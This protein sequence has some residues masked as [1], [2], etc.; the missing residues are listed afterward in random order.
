MQGEVEASAAGRG[1]GD[2][3]DQQTHPAQHQGVSSA[4][5]P[6]PTPAHLRDHGPM[7][8][9]PSL[10]HWSRAQYVGPIGAK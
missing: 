4:Y 10:A 5:L 2:P 1:G 6:P 9:H 3:Q 8:G 7:L